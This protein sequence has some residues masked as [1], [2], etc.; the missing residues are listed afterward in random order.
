MKFSQTLFQRP[1]F[2]SLDFAAL[3]L[4]DFAVGQL[5]RGRE[6][7][8]SLVSCQL[9]SLFMT[10]LCQRYS[11]TAS[12]PPRHARLALA[13]LDRLI[14]RRLAEPPSNGELAAAINLSESHFICLFQR[15]LG[16]TPQQYVMNRRLQRAQYLL[17]NSA[18]PLAAV[19]DEV[20]FADASSFSRAYKRRFQTTP[21]SLRR[22]R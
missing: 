21:G 9:V 14:D 10:Q 17:L 18:L 5:Q 20:G 2:V 19:A 6:Q 12:L 1:E 4:L 3:P 7:A 8:D 16:V 11:A 15:Q 22:A 13:E